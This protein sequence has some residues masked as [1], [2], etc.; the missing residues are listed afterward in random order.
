[1]VIILH[2]FVFYCVFGQINAYLTN[3]K[4]LND[5]VGISQYNVFLYSQITLIDLLN[6]NPKS[7]YIYIYI[8][9]CIYIH[10]H[11]HIYMY[12]YICVYISVCECIFI[13]LFYSSSSSKKVIFSFC[14]LNYNFCHSNISHY[15]SH[16]KYN[17]T[18]SV[19]LYAYSSIIA[20][21][22]P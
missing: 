21:I 19:E 22:T 6:Q 1:M 18:H 11:T 17:K 15:F 10:T 13:Y 8:Y 12:V 20:A 3:P 16:H 7:F 2:N 5:S 14:T 4:L 9:I